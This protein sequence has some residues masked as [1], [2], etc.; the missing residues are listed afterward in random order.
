[1][2]KIIVPFV[3]ISILLLASLSFNDESD[4][5][6][7]VRIAISSR[8][9]NL[10]PFFSTDANSQNMNRLIYLSLV[11]FDEEMQ[12]VCRACLSYEETF[13]NDGQYSLRFE[14]K[15]GLKFHDGKQIKARDFHQSWKYF[16]DQKK[17]K[18]IFAG[19]FSSIAEIKVLSDYSFEIFYD[20]FREDALANLVLLKILKWNE[21]EIIGSGEYKLK[22]QGPLSVKLTSL[23]DARPDLHFYV[24]RDE[25]TLA[26]KLVRGEIDFSAAHLS[27]RKIEW[28]LNS[29]GHKLNFHRVKTSNYIYIS[30]NHQRPPF[31]KWEI[32]RAIAS[33]IPREEI[34]EYKLKGNAVI[35]HGMF[36]PAFPRFFNSE[37]NDYLITADEAIKHLNQ[38]GITAENPLGIFWPTPSTPSTL[39]L[40]LTMKDYLERGPIKVNVRPSE[41]GTYMRSFTRG[42]FDL[43]LGQWI[44]FS[45]PDMLNFAFHSDSVPPSGGNRGRYFN[46]AVDK[47]LNKA[48]QD[49]EK[50]E[51][52]YKNASLMVEKDFAYISLWHPINTWI[53][54]KCVGTDK[55][56]PNSSF[57]TFLNIQKE[58]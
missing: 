7:V 43:V 48:L 10:S 46:D 14:L 25:T 38:M 9:N 13:H 57:K 4:Q 32:R 1:M 18:S 42:E 3:L 11:D 27:A 39:E 26:L 31:D 50:R 40:I 56:F 37:K 22:Q 19:A 58:C 49:P 28:L 6:H 44:G 41:W 21:N 52:Y 8:P 29:Y 12:V 30:F 35:S 24:I 15:K 36:S 34:I 17:I 23:S 47:M 53:S 54:R 20:Q 5:N 2:Y 55:K 33:L 16:T 51:I 45:G